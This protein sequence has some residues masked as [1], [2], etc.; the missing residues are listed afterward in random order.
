[1]RVIWPPH[2]ARARD[3]RGA[4]AVVIAICSIVMF[5]MA[6]F[7]LDTGNLWTSRRHLITA[8]DSA[9]LGAAED[10]AV[11][12]AGCASTAP[13][14]LTTN[15]AGTALTSCVYTAAGSGA[16]YVTVTGGHSVNF[17]FAQI[18]G[19]SSSTVHSTTAAAFGL[20][21]GLTGLRPL[22]LCNASAG[23]RNWLNSGM[24]TPFTQKIFIT[25]DSPNDCGANAPGNWGQLQLDP[26]CP[27]NN[28]EKD[29]WA[30][31]Y[32]GIVNSDTLIGAKPG[33]FSNSISSDL[34]ALEA[35]GQPFQLPVYDAAS[36]NGRNAEFHIIGFVTLVLINHSLTGAQASRY[37]TVQFQTGVAQGS[38]CSQGTDTG[39]RVVFICAVDATFDP[40]HC[41][42]HQ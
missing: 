3:E 14:L 38:C 22:G 13:S 41:T 21:T 36:G 4:I 17:S 10:Y 29:Q 16:G 25:K 20:P 23:F 5:G 34:S 18:F 42:S 1:M 37:I 40:S 24:S 9:A 11:G 39:T 35:S 6:A 33:A 32:Q 8:T 19:L 15:Y 2:G 7:V 26:N 30:N 28:C 27:G 31:G 12:K